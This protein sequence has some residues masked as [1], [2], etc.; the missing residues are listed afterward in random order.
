MIAH[1]ATLDQ[2]PPVESEPERKPGD[3]NVGGRRANPNAGRTPAMVAMT[4]G[5]GP[6][7]T[8]GPAY[9][10][11]GAAPFREAGSRK[12][13]EAL[14]RVVKGMIPHNKLGAQQYRKLR[15]YAGATHPHV[16]QNPQV[17]ELQD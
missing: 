15:V 4:G 13:E 5:R 6:A 8:G 11:D 1:G 10:R 3:I 2:T 9:I 7:M 14:R 12:P 16:G 17:R